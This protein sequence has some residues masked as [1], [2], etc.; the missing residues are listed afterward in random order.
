MSDRTLEKLEPRVG[1]TVD[2]VEGFTVEAG[3]VAEFAAAVGDDNPVFVDEAAAADRGFDR[4]PAPP[5]FTRTSMFPRYRPEGVGR[6]GIDI[7][8]DIRYEL[9]G[10]QVYE[11]ARPVFVGDTL[12]A[13]TTLTDAYER[14]G[15]QGGRMTFAVLETEFVDETGGPVVTE[16]QTV[17]ETDGTV[18]DGQ[19]EP[20]RPERDANPKRGSVSQPSSA[21][22]PVDA[23]DEVS[24]GDQ[25]PTVI[26]EDIAPQDFVRYA[27]ASGDFNPIHYD[28]QYA[29]AL[30]NPGVFGQG[31]LT[32]AHTG[33][34]AADWFGVGAISRFSTRFTARVWP[35]D[36][37]TVDGEVTDVDGGEVTADVTATRQTGE[38]V[39]VGEVTADVS[40]DA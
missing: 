7:G 35:G 25:P 10:E 28:E 37:L 2:S 3:K 22:Y 5:T 11:F 40:G 34:L 26:V 23:P 15:R 27:G 18:S 33:H 16:R 31:M 13:T 39:L 38:S 9:H 20:E 30:G 32:A 14:E 12:S 21:G 19:Q 29:T 4:R 6:L 17:I 36:T 1:D 8:F 24:V